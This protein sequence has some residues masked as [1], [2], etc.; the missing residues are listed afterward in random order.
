LRGSA[1]PAS[2]GSGATVP[3][4]GTFRCGAP[5]LVPEDAMPTLSIDPEKVCYLIALARQFQ[6]K[7]EPN[8]GSNMADD[9]FREVLEDYANDAVMIEMRQMLA[10]LNVEE[11]ST[12]LALL[13]LGRGDYD[14]A[15]WNAALAEAENLRSERG[16]NY[17]I[18]TPLLSDYL[19]EG[20]NQLGYS[21]EDT[22]SGT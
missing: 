5:L 22:E 14:K 6:A 11:Y 19:E 21:C 8:P 18:G 2:P 7:V 10:D 12:M 1:V 4:R 17:L 3:G 20:L 16:P 13:W 9:G 15:E